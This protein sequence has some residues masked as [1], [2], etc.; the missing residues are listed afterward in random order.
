MTV[1]VDQGGDGILRLVL[2]KP[3][4]RNALDDD[5]VA[6]LIDAVDGAGREESVRAI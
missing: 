3:A 6:T 2:D 4:K 1:H 5:M